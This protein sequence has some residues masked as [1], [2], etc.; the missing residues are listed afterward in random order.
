MQMTFWFTDDDSTCSRPRDLRHLLTLHSSCCDVSQPTDQLAFNLV[1]PSPKVVPF[2][3]K[4]NQL[5]LD[6]SV[7]DMLSE[8]TESRLVVRCLN[9]WGILLVG[10]LV[11]CSKYTIGRI[12]P[13]L[14]GLLEEID[15]E[16]A[17][18]GFRLGMS[19]AHWRRPHTRFRLQA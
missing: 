19:L 15:T 3:A 9:R 18:Y 10:D 5:Y 13:K 8:T 6:Y 4:R 7:Q 17:H 12:V 1:I 2:L 16:L 11:Q 14:P